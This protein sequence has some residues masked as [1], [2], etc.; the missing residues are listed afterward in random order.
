MQLT[1]YLYFNGQC[2]EAFKF[3]ERTLGA[4]I[5]ATFFYA[6]TPAEETVPQKWRNKVL[7]ARMILEGNEL[8]AADVPP[9]QY[10][11]PQGFH[12]A[13]QFKNVGDGQR[14]FDALSENGSVHYPFQKTFWSP[15]F[16]LVVDRFGIP[17]MI[18]CEQP[19]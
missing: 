3:Y 13:I 11:K 8:N 16:G 12:V 6:G 10:V 1:P 14:A 15:G 7:H 5:G 9:E 18:N 2:G 19:T 4:T 17:W